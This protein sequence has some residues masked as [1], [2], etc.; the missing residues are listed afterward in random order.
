MVVLLKVAW[1]PVAE[2]PLMFATGTHDGVVKV[3]SSPKALTTFGP[4]KVI[5]Q[6]RL[7]PGL[8]KGNR[9]VPNSAMPRQ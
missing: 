4:P 2:R 9:Y 5:D 6:S 7:G 3:R 8:S 1:H